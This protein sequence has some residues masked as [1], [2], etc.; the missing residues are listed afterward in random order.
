MSSSQENKSTVAMTH[1]HSRREAL[2]SSQII[3][4][5]YETQL[6]IVCHGEFGLVSFFCH[7]LGV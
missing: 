3:S 1:E 2:V 7:V 5:Q 6:M 4:R